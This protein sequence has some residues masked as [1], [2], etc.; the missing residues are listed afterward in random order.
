MAL[1]ALGQEKNPPA[2]N[3]SAN[4]SLGAP[5]PLEKGQLEPRSFEKGVL[6]ALTVLENF[7]AKQKLGFGDV[8][9]A[10]YYNFVFKSAVA[11]AQ[12]AGLEFFIIKTDT[13]G[14]DGR[15]K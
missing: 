7:Q 1:A 9:V 2:E 10:E 8:S 5:V 12:R 15:Q 6:Y 11:E 13:L 14:K 3:S 4:K